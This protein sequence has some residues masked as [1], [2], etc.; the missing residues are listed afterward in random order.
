MW[1]ERALDK[2]RELAKRMSADQLKAFLVK[3]I[4]PLTTFKAAYEA[5]CLKSKE[6]EDLNQIADIQPPSF[7]KQSDD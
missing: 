3:E 4:A 1:K 6:F 7:P 5:V 2:I